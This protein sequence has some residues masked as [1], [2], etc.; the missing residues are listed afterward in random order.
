MNTSTYSMDMVFTSYINGNI[1][2]SVNSE[3]CV[4][5]LS[6]R[7]TNDKFHNCFVVF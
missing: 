1:K 3:S 2:I 4:D 5:H 7:H 6:F